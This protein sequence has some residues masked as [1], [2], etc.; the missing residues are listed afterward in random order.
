MCTSVT[1]T[2]PMSGFGKGASGWFALT[3]ASVYVDHPYHAPY[4]HTVNIDFA[5]PN[6]GPAASSCP[7]RPA[8][9]NGSAPGSCGFC[10]GGWPRHCAM[11]GAISRAVSMALRQ[12][13][14]FSASVRGRG[15][16]I[17][18]RAQVR[19]K[20]LAGVSPGVC[21]YAAAHRRHSR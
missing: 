12:A 18:R 17:S 21:A 14:R 11:S 3:Q 6:A 7:M 20:A 19:R 13:R 15:D 5:N 2:A 4:E 9:I 10:S 8:G 1:E 16:G